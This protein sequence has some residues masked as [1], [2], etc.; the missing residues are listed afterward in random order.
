MGLIVDRTK[1]IWFRPTTASHGA[2]SPDVCCGLI[3]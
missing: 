3:V 1:K 2:T